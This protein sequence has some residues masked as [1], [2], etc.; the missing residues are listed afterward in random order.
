MLEAKRLRIALIEPDSEFFHSFKLQ[1]QASHCIVAPE[2]TNLEDA[3]LVL[4]TFKSVGVD[5][6]FVGD[7]GGANPDEARLFIAEIQKN[8][9]WIYTISMSL[10]TFKFGADYDSYYSDLNSPENIE[11]LLSQVYMAKVRGTSSN[12]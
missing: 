2:A 1:L 7:I 6:A 4:P 8:F 11:W 3:R 10:T 5:G 9:P 12:T